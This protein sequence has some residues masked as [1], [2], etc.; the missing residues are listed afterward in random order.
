MKTVKST[1]E[2]DCIFL[3]KDLTGIIEEITLEEK[4]SLIRQGVNY[5][6][7]ISKESKPSEDI[8]NIFLKMME[9]DK[10]IIAYYVAKI[11]ETMY[12]E[13]GNNL[14]LVSLARA[15][16]P[17]GILVKKYFKF[18]FNLEVPHYSISI[19]RG[20]GIDINALKYILK[21]NP[22][23]RIQFIDG[24]T[25]KGSI[26]K[27]LDKSI[28]KFNHE[29]NTNIDNSLAVISDPAKLCSICGTTEDIG[30]PSCC[31]NATVS[32]LISRTIHN[33]RY[34]GKDDFHGAKTLEYLKDDD[35]SQGFINDIY[36]EFSKIKINEA[37]LVTET[38][39]LNYSRNIT[40]DI[41]RCYNIKNINNIKL[42]VGE[43][44]RVLLRREPRIIL[45]KNKNDKN[46]EHI[47]QLSKEKNVEVVEYKNS[48]YN[49]IAIIEEELN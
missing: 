6:E 4:E 39:D 11:S 34:I 49:C 46:V 26:T 36:D 19:I 29:N 23:G 8:K 47:I 33:P 31:L 42:S 15:G 3:L 13:K 44:A 1:Y 12:R 17:Y 45:V 48:D 30:I 5:S 35:Y 38:K 28:R 25:G 9:R 2:N 27:E 7:M 43:S 40:E 16:T 14:I 41:Q 18:K 20:K 22:Q 37:D 32:G 21:E 10:N 24:W